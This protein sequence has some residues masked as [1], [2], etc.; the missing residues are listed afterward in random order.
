MGVYF[1]SVFT[2]RAESFFLYPYCSWTLFLI[3]WYKIIHF[4]SSPCSSTLWF[5]GN[6][7][8]KVWF[9]PQE[10]NMLSIW[11]NLKK[12]KLSK[13][14]LKKYLITDDG[15]DMLKYLYYS[16]IW[17]NW[18]SGSFLLSSSFDS[19]TFAPA[20]DWGRMEKAGKSHPDCINSSNP[21]H[22]CV[23]FC[24]KRIAEAKA[25]DLEGK[26]WFFSIFSSV[27]CNFYVKV[28]FIHFTPFYA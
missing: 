10:S 27:S 18:V 26:N 22:E 3:V 13:P 15:Y 8:L 2:Q 5:E 12:I 28:H 11:T 21:Y 20:K 19:Q 9:L 14:S 1:G 6:K 23:E 17:D 4:L 16:I 7:W 25:Q 24:F